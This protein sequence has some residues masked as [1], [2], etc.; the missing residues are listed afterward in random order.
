MLSQ[1]RMQRY[2]KNPKIIIYFRIL[3]FF[4]SSVLR[5]THHL[6]PFKVAKNGNHYIKGVE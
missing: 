1:I 2:K 5:F 6:P 3:Y 4:I